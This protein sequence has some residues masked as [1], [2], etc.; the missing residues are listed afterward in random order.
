MIKSRIS[1]NTAENRSLHGLWCD[2]LQNDLRLHNLNTLLKQGHNTFG[3]WNTNKK[4]FVFHIHAGKLQVWERLID[5]AHKPDPKLH[6]IFKITEHTLR[7][8]QPQYTTNCK[9]HQVRTGS[10]LSTINADNYPVTPSPALI[11]TLV[12]VVSDTQLYDIRLHIKHLLKDH[13]LNWRKGL[14]LKHRS[15]SLTKDSCIDSWANLYHR[16]S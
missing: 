5:I 8:S 4:P 12:W 6:Q 10:R 11:V 16:T 13:K 2:T 9:G 15:T 7:T 3:K 1:G 14:R